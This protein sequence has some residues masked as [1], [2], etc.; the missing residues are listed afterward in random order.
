MMNEI[1]GASYVPSR[2]SMQ[3]DKTLWAKER[4]LVFKNAVTGPP[5]FCPKALT[6]CANSEKSAGG[7]S[8]TDSIMHRAGHRNEQEL[9]H[10][11]RLEG[12]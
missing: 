7:F 9:K 3:L 12:E 8:I 2:Y 5:G 10:S 1:I 4:K 11:T 6:M